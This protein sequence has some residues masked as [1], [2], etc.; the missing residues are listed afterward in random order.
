MSLNKRYKLLLICLSFL[1]LFGIFHYPILASSVNK[2]RISGADRYQTAI[3]ISQKGWETSDYA[4]LVRGDDFADALSAGPLAHKFSA[5]ILM[6]QPRKINN[7]ILNEL[8]RLGVKHLIII[9]GVDAISQDIED[10]L[11]KEG[12]VTIKRIHGANRYQTSVKI[13]E[14]LSGSEVVLASGDNYSETLSIAAIASKRS[15]PILLTRKEGLPIEIQTF[16]S[17]TAVTKTYIIGGI[18]VID[19]KVDEQ[20]PEPFRLAGADRFETSAII[21]NE[22]ADEFDCNK[23]YITRSDNEFADGLSGAVLAARTSSPLVMVDK[24]RSLAAIDCLKDK[25]TKDTTIIGIGCEQAVPSIVL[26]ALAS[27]IADLVNKQTVVNYW[28]SEEGSASK[29]PVT[30]SLPSAIKISTKNT[31]PP[32]GSAILTAVGGPLS[33]SSWQ[34]ILEHIKMNTDNGDNW[35]TGITSSDLTIIPADDGVTA[36]IKNNS[37][38]EAIISQ[39]F[40]IP[41]T[42]VVNREGKVAD[43]DIIIDSHIIVVTGVLS[44]TPDGHYKEGESIII[45]IHFSGKVDVTGTPILLLETGESVGQAVYSAGSGTSVLAF[46]Y[47]VESEHISMKLDYLGE[48]SLDLNDGSIKMADGE[49]GVLLT[50]ATPGGIGS[51]SA[52]KNIVIDN[53]PPNMIIISKQNIIPKGGSVTLTVVGGPLSD[54]SWLNILNEI[55]SN[56]NLGT[57]IRGI[58]RNNL[59]ITICDDGITATLNNTNTAND[60][61]IVSDFLIP[62]PKVID[63][64]GNVAVIDIVI[65]SC[66]GD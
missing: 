21:I 43:K 15:M 25:L 45:T 28:D 59:T 13:A 57:W 3:A 7:D 64:A 65:D 17:N 11:K 34:D 47:T 40:V 6:T 54:L 56:I 49:E 30:P 26:N 42:K 58:I 62:A 37:S 20:V 22:F 39:D 38:Q 55:K 29:P 44:S 1:C 35:I 60:A 5:P 10:D 8:V 24:N 32:A 2:E 4:I 61:I 16:L 19:G 27:Y 36:T 50:L 14:E 63:R 52:D 9:G 23:I 33:V 51:L 18:G 31:I 66:G 46:T 53:N 48:D 41:A 12:K